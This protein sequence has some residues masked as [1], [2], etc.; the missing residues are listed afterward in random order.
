MKLKDDSCTRERRQGCR[1]EMKGGPDGLYTDEVSFGLGTLG[2]CLVFG[3]A[4]LGLRYPAVFQ[5]RPVNVW[6]SFSRGIGGHR[7]PHS[8]RL[9]AH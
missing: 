1:T 5:L 9:E 7:T 2:E 3:G 6:G 4:E 8:W